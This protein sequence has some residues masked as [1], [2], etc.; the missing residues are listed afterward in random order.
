MEYITKTS[1]PC[2]ILAGAGTG[3]TYNIIEKLKYLINKKVYRPEEIVCLTFSNEAV[4][5]IRQRM[6]PFLTDNKEPVI[7]TFHSYCADILRKN[8]KKIGIKENFKILSEDDGKILIHKH[9]KTHPSLCKKYVE[10]I[11]ISKDLG[12]LVEKLEK[13]INHST[14]ELEDLSKELEKLQFEV[15]TAHLKKVNL[16]DLEQIKTRK[17]SIEEE[18]KQRK[19]IQTWK[20]YEKIKSLKN[21]LDYA[22]LNQKALELLE[23]FP[24]SAEG[25]KYLIIDE[26]QD[27]NKLQCE[28]IKKIAN[29]RNI[30]IVGD[31]NQSIYQFRGA[32][33]E[34]FNYIKKELNISASDLF[35]L[36]KSYRST[37]KILEV[38]HQL[39]KNNYLNPKE[40][41][42]V[43]SARNEEGEPVKIYELKNAKEEVRKTIEIIREELSNGTPMHEICVIF[44]THQQA[45]LLKKELTLQS[46]PYVTITKDSL[47][48]K[49]EIKKVRA[50]LSLIN[51]Y[52]TSSNGGSSAWWELMHVSS[53]DKK[54]EIQYSKALYD[55]QKKEPITKEIVDNGIP[56]LSEQTEAKLKSIIKIIKEISKNP[57]VHPTLKCEVCLGF[58]DASKFL[59][60][61]ICCTE[62]FPKEE[63]S[64]AQSVPNTLT[65]QDADQKTPN[66]IKRLYHLLGFQN[67]NTKEEQEN[68]LILDKFH[69]LAKDFSET[70]SSELGLFLH[71]L[72]TLDALNVSIDAPIIAKEGIRIMTNHATKGLEYIAMIMSAMAQN[73]F[74][75][76]KKESNILPI[77]ESNDEESQLAEERRLCYVGCTR[78]K[79]RLYLTYAKEYGARSS[80]PS[81]FL[82]EMNCQ[83]NDNIQFIKDEKEIYKES[84]EPSLPEIQNASSIEIESLSFSASSL[85]KFDECQ[86]KYEY[87]YIYNMP[88]PTP[89]SWEAITLGNFVHRVL[90]EGVSKNLRT[91]KEFEDCAKTI[92]M[93]EFKDS[94][95]DETLP[96]I[97]TFF[98]RNKQKYNENS[99]TEQWLSANLDG[100]KFTGYADRIDVNDEGEVTIIDYKTGK[101]DVKPKYRNWQLG[102]YAL[103]SRKFGT[104]QTLILEMLQ[105][106]H[107]LEFEIDS[108]G[109]AKEVH[110]SRIQ[111]SLQEVKQ[112]LV[113]TAK[114]IIQ[115]RQTS[116]KPCP[117]EK[118]CE[119]CEEWIY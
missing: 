71:H 93:E 86:K 45:N 15:N 107:P 94:N 89:Q 1:G 7:R 50:Y 20:A 113:E 60:N 48:K 49:P 12:Y 83:N 116:F 43:K 118:N 30:T 28:L 117:I 51:K 5:T 17:E 36:D 96:L 44:R 38:A 74:P 99:L 102:L 34:N 109:V 29:H 56:N 78:A 95:L 106:D 81:Q 6:L 105:K 46:I 67:A 114:K 92:Q 100:L 42:E 13:S 110:S 62:I 80:V 16:S 10:E 18:V 39:I 111:F 33:K 31:L 57:C 91:I 3:K 65:S 112:E 25:C 70:D 8:G 85:Q 47:L 98:E 84:K 103:A 68:I 23:K 63:I 97:R 73:K 66:I 82:K 35:K 77:K 55:L 76:S 119:F 59:S 4:N 108:K 54:D 101:S 22:D 40:C 11:G 14:R 41:F 9:L 90:E 21:C 104:P 24:E 75:I 69:T 115:A 61:G 87:K 79:K 2:V 72:E 52:K 27:T 19:F 88:E 32:Y 58:L 64:C 53:L 37:N 26:F